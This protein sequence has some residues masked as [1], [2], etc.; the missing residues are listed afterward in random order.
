MEAFSIESVRLQHS[1][2]FLFGFSVITFLHITAGEQAPK[3]LAIQKP[4]THLALG[5][6]AALV[7]RAASYPFIWALNEASNKMLRW[8]GIESVS[9]HDLIHSEEELRMLISDTHRQHGGHC[10]GKGYCVQ[11]HGT[12][13][14]AW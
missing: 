4:I 13:P 9:E 8:V 12:A 5:C 6:Q 11:C 1:L 10:A 2:S 7:V 3:L 14:E